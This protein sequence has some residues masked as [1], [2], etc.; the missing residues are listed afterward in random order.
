MN[1]L[2]FLSMGDA[3][4]WSTSII[5]ITDFAMMFG[6]LGHVEQGKDV[7]FNIPDVICIH[8]F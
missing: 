2:Y 4:Y 5:E 8:K 7:S 6:E 3:I 1:T